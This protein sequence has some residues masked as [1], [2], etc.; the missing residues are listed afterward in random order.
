MI[1]TV[2][3]LTEAMFYKR[4]PGGRVRCD[5]C[6]HRCVIDN[7]QAGKCSVRVNEGGDF[8]LNTPARGIVAHADPIEKKPFYHFLPGSKCYSVGAFGCNMD[9]QYC[10]NWELSQP[11]ARGASV[12]LFPYIPPDEAVS[13]AR[14]RGCA[15]MAFTFTEPAV[16]FEYVL[17]TAQLAEAAG[18]ANVIKTNGFVMP[19]PLAMLIPRLDAANVDLKSMCERTYR[20]LGGQLQPSRFGVPIDNCAP[21]TFGSK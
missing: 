5:V 8:Y 10:I 9:C 11:K 13:Q 6:P 15:G 16:F 7:S 1:G 3:G 20:H 19:E 12:S 21:R 18:L 4:L 17:E 14:A 2:P